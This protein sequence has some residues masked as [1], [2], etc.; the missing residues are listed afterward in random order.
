VRV[1]AFE[2]WSQPSIKPIGSGC[3]MIS[4][5]SS[6]VLGLADEQGQTSF[7]VIGRWTL[8]RWTFFSD[9]LSLHSNFSEEF[10]SGNGA[11]IESQ[12]QPDDELA[13]AK[14]QQ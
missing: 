13:S 14:L 6:G 11:Y 4:G 3:A 8:G 2:G 1:L 10:E 9:K 12:V 5:I 7:S